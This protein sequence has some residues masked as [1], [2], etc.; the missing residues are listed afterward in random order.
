MVDH[1]MIVCQMSNCPLAIGQKGQG[2]EV[3]LQGNVA[4]VFLSFFVFHL[5][6]AAA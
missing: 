4:F 6:L 5:V 1:A 2:D 3:V